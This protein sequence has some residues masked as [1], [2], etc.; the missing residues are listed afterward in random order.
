MAALVEQVEPVDGLL[1]GLADGQETVVAQERSAFVA[2]RFGDVVALVSGQD[3]SFPVEDDVVL[4]CASSV[5]SFVSLRLLMETNVV[6]DRALQR[7]WIQLLAQGTKCPTIHAVR[8]CRAQHIRPRRMNRPMDQERRLVEHFYLAMVQNVALVVHA[9]EV[10]LTDPIEVY[11]KGIDPKG[12]WLDGVT[13]GDVARESF[14]EVVV[15][16]D[17]V[18]E[19]KAAFDV[20]PF[21]I[22]IWEGEVRGREETDVLVS[23]ASELF[24]WSGGLGGV[25]D[26]E[27]GGVDDPRIGEGFG[28]HCVS[29]VVQRALLLLDEGSLDEGECQ[30]EELCGCFLKEGRIQIR[31]PR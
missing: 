20:F 18:G 14:I 9:E 3:N 26:L 12:L 21:L 31:S 28:S 6:E 29:R 27:G 8:V 13:D 19:G 23:G 25:R 1:D 2:Q 24:G 30:A 17:A 11:T 22:F 10:T 7:N 4:S 5:V 15:P 16:E